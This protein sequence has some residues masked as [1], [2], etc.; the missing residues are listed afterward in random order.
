[1][2][3]AGIRS[4]RARLALGR[5]AVGGLPLGHLLALLARLGE[6]DG[7]RLLPAL[8]RAALAAFAALERALLAAVHGAFHVLAGAARVPGHCVL[9]SP[10]NAGHRAQFHARR[11]ASVSAVVICCEKRSW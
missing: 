7:D 3:P 4:L 9:P 6:A 10:A 1:M 11:I 5:L 2:V 8:H